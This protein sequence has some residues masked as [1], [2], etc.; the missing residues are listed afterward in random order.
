MVARP[1]S[2]LTL[3]VHFFSLVL[4]PGNLSMLRTLL[5]SL[6]LL[7]CLMGGA[8]SSETLQR[9]NYGVVFQTKSALQ[10]SNEYWLHT[11]KV[12]LP[13][14]LHLPSIGT[15]HKDDDTCILIGHV[16]AQINT[17][18][19]ETSARLN[20]TLETVY[21]LIPESTHI[22]G[23]GKRSLLPFLG[24]LSRTIFGTA[25]LDDI[26]VLARH[27]NE[28]TRRSMKISNAIEQHGAHMSSFME[29]ANKRMD[30][31]MDGV[32]NNEMAINYVH[33]QLQTS[34][35]DLQNNFEQM[36]SILTKQ[37]QQ[38][39][40]LNHQLDEIKLGIIDLV[41]GKLSPLILPPELLQN[42]IKEVQALL[43][44][45]YPEF[46]VAHTP[47]DQLY[48]SENFLYARYNN[49]LFITIKLP[50]SA[51]KNNLKLFDVKSF[52]VPINNTSPQATQLLDL[53]AHFAI[54]ADQQFYTTLS[55]SE[56]SRCKGEKPLHCF[57]NKPL[58]P[59]TTE[60]C[61][62]ALFTNSK[63]KVHALCNFRFLQN[64]IKPSV[65]EIGISSVVVYRSPILSMECSKQHKM[66]KGCDYCILA[67]PCRC[68]LF[69]EKFYFPPRLTACH[70]HTNNVT[71]LHPLNLVLLQEFFDDTKIQNVFA[72]TTFENPLNVTVPKFKIYQHDMHKIIADD[73]N[74]HLSLSRMT[75]QV[76]NDQVIFQSL[77]EPLLDGQLKI[78]PQWPDFN[79]F[80]IFAT[81]GAI[82]ICITFMTW[83]FFKMRKLT[84]LV[85]A[86]SQPSAAKA[87]STEV[88]SFVYK[89]A[90]KP[91]ESSSTFV[92]DFE[93]AWDHAIF[94]LCL[95]NFVW[96]LLNTYNIIKHNNRNKSMIKLEVTSGDL[97]VL[98]S[99]MQL[100]LCPVY[101]HIE[102]PS[103]ICSLSV[104]GPWYAKKLK[105]NLENFS[106]TNTQ[107][108]K[109]L[110]VPK[111]I[112]I[113][114]L[115]SRKLE[116]ILNRTF[117]VFLH[118][119]HNGFLRLVSDHHSNVSTM[120]EKP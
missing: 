60:S 102:Q 111:S 49:S 46:F 99:V 108:N 11:Y 56:I 66:I 116:K 40:H 33:S 118:V 31:L 103:D 3:H 55:D 82:T 117:L 85:A 41:K 25:T 94:L 88:P 106:V 7:C 9:M 45:K 90:P 98:L 70:N 28:L 39:N 80:L 63:E 24:Q 14:G 113:S 75:D 109:S 51:H 6:V 19:A 89:H 10:L 81:M 69:T 71:K 115:Q 87:M 105:V 34:I 13:A 58:T 100:P 47:V 119:Q 96:F 72:D 95:I 36:S 32:K 1:S 120:L 15:C 18:R 21:R 42:T 62:L 5:W 20:H 27:I 52:P 37:I 92:I 104:K 112:K 76:K 53:P 54:S 77:T 4:G 97:C 22:K 91:T 110:S 29:K 57:F 107:N 74:S 78:E 23:R 38:S 8:Q 44:S 86:L 84:A 59:I 26:N 83:T 61:I 67:L 68:S 114:Y 79:A 2:P 12:P 16:L 30:N 43:N 48:K 93:V 65:H 64:T 17:V 73:K 101:C 50:I 35:R